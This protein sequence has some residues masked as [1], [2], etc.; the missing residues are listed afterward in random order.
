M[1][2]P[3]DKSGK[4]G[5]GYDKRSPCDAMIEGRLRMP[6]IEGRFAASAARGIAIFAAMV[7]ALGVTASG[8]K[9]TP[10]H[11]A[12][13]AVQ[14]DVSHDLLRGCGADGRSAKH[15]EVERVRGGTRT[16][17]FC[18]AADRGD[19]RAAARALSVA[20][21]AAPPRSKITSDPRVLDILSLRLTRARTE[22]DIR[23]DLDARNRKLTE[24]DDAVKRL[25]DET[26]RVR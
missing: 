2:N 25:E 3:F 22:M 26:S 21:D 5:A 7:G 18:N 19:L 6:S 15:F 23:M 12:E 9:A 8:L 13:A 1:A 14:D 10:E 20:I 4:L 11:P 24:I 16:I 17:D